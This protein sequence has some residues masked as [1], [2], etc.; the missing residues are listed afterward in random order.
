MIWKIIATVVIL[1]AL[2][3]TS[4]IAVNASR[5]SV[6]SPAVVSAVAPVYGIIARATRAKGDVTVEVTVN[7]AGDVT[8]VR[9]MGGSR[10]LVAAV[11]EAAKRWR[12]AQAND[13]SAVRTATLVFVFTLM[14]RCSPVT[15]EAT[16]FYPPYKIEVHGEPPADTC[17]D[18]SPAAQE[19]LRCK[20]P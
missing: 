4:W 11:K 5:E 13:T 6:E 1:I 2:L 10:F 17:D 20:N 18:C 15:D 12:F 19:K 9:I 8:D 7:A 3:A 16:G 14:P